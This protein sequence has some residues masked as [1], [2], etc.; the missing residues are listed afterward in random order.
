MRTL[1]GKAAS[2]LSIILKGLGQI[3]L[4]ENSVT[5]LLF[6][7]GIFY[8]SIAMGLAALLATICGTVTADL[9]KYDKAEITQGLYGFSAALV[10]VA[11]MLFLKPVFLSWVVIVIGSVLAAILQ[12]F[13]IKRKIPAFTL[14][15]VLVTWLVLF[16]FKHFGKD[17]LALPTPVILHASDSLA[18]GFKSFGQVMFQ[19]NLVSGL[20]FFLAVFISSPIA[21]LYGLAAAIVSA[22]IAFIFSA[23]IDDINLGLYGF[24]AV[25]CAIV[26]AGDKV[27]DGIWVLVAVVFALGVS[28]LLIHLN[29]PQLTFPFVLA[30]WIT[31]F[32]KGKLN[33]AKG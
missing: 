22:I 32:L 25:L 30:T 4:Q 27:R 16:V 31:L 23:P 28:L 24:N 5:G 3:M 1:V 20:L 9:L 2:V 12:H 29:I 21:A 7:I 6:L 10:G 26:F 11:V 17:L 8:G 33:R 14:P 13:F 18:E 19:N 15:F